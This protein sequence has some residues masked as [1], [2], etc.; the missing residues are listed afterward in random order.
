[1]NEPRLTLMDPD[2]HRRISE[3]CIYICAFMIRGV[4][5]EW[6]RSDAARRTPLSIPLSNCPAN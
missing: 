1:M 5:A 4:G 2:A 6:P 3:L